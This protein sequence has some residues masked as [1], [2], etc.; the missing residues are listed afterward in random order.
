MGA[1]MQ[2]QKNQRSFARIALV[3][4]AMF[5]FGYLLV[6]LYDV[7]CEITG[8]GGRTN[9]TAAVVEEADDVRAELERVG[10]AEIQEAADAERYSEAIQILDKLG[11]SDI[12]VTRLAFG[13]GSR[14]GRIQRELGKKEFT[15][16]GGEALSFDGVDDWVLV[17]DYPKADVAMTVTAKLPRS[18][19]S[20]AA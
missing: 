19:G 9:T 1:G 13:T 8:L 2:E 6:P 5:G 11:K 15:R 4:V 7:F 20:G 3:A 18:P 17:S 14:G 10:A 12:R 16:L